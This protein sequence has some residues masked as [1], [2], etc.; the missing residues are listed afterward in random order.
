[1]PGNKPVLA[2]RMAGIAPFHVMDI[3]AKAREMDARGLDVVHMEVGEPDFSSPRPVIEAGI[4]SLQQGLTHYTPALGLPGPL[5]T[6]ICP[7]SVC[8]WM[9]PGSS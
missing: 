3:L 1:M 7:A 4:R 5:P 9:R 6:I 8:R 2:H